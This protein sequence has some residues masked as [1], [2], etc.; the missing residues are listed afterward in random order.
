M[1]RLRYRIKILLFT[2]GWIG[3]LLG[4]VSNE[5]YAQQRPIFSQYMFNGLVLNPAY[6]GNQQQ[7]EVSLVH[8]DQWVN[9]EGAPKTQSLVT[10]TALENRPMGVGLIVSRD[11]IGIHDDYSIYGSYAYKIKLLVGTL[12]LGLQGGFNYTQSNFE[13]LRRA[14]P[15][16]PVLSGTQTRFSPNFG[17]GA[18]YSNSR[19]YAGISVPYL[20]NNDVYNAADVLSEARERRYY[21]LTGGHV[22]TLSPSIKLMPSTLIRYQEGQP[23]NMDLNANAFFQDVINLGVSYRSGDSMIG[24]LEIILN[25]NFSFGYTYDHTI[26]RISTFTDGTHEFMLSYR[27]NIGNS[28]CHSYF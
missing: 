10:H 28:K 16:D 23:V 18:F 15:F 19:T 20:L 14:S 8:R 6:A 17:T 3:L 1:K 12:S 11:Q 5:G 22:F 25:R 2:I 13:K 27:L 24:L 21:F 26:S 4:L 9:V 7:W